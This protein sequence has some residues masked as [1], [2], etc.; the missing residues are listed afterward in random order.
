M[1]KVHDLLLKI[2]D[3]LKK[4]EIEKTR[5]LLKDHLKG[6]L[7]SIDCIDFLKFLVFTLREKC[8]N[9]E[10]FLVLIFLHSDYFWDLRRKSPYS[11]R[12]QKNTDQKKLSIW[13]LSRSGNLWKKW[14]F[15]NI[16][17]KLPVNIRNRST[18]LNQ[19]Q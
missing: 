17:E 9:T 5:F 3:S 4:D 13:T 11:V 19:S 1:E 14:L 15:A 7:H 16:H 12:I 2:G 6:K 10:F 8:L 18:F